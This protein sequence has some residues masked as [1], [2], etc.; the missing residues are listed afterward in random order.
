MAITYAGR[1]KS[2]TELNLIAATRIHDSSYEYGDYAYDV[3][4][5]LR[6]IRKRDD[7]ALFETLA[8][9]YGVN[10]YAPVT[11]EMIEACDEICTKILR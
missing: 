1:G 6:R 4:A 10:V 3:E 8:K 5:S 11:L 7:R 2:Y 9:E